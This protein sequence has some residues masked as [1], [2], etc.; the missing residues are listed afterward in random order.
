MTKN[1]DEVK[2]QLGKIEKQQDENNGIVN[3]L[4]EDENA[5]RK[6]YKEIQGNVQTEISS[7]KR[8]P[9]YHTFFC[10]N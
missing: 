10:G 2:K 6:S 1:L 5:I 4:M 8:Y 9:R 3:H 7:K